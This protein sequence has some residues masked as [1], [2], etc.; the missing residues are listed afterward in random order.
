MSSSRPP[1]GGPPSRDSSSGTDTTSRWP[2]GRGPSASSRAVCSA[3]ATP[4]F[5]S[6]TPGPVAALP[7]PAKRPGGRRALGK[8]VS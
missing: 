7:V 1:E 8:T 2:N 3:T 4:P 5:M 6:A